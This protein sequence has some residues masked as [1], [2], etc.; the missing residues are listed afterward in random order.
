MW[1]NMEVY[2]I[3]SSLH[4]ELDNVNIKDGISMVEKAQETDSVNLENKSVVT[5]PIS[6]QAPSQTNNNA[7]RVHTRKEQR[8]GNTLYQELSFQVTVV[9]F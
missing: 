9:K 6:P 4:S 1:K 2:F 3:N 5:S 8:S 7:G